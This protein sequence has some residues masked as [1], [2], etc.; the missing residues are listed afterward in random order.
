MQPNLSMTLIL[1]SYLIF[2]FIDRP[3]T[4]YRG[5]TDLGVEGLTDWMMESRMDAF[6]ESIVSV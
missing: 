2:D 5:W 4:V 3:L 6:M 1:I